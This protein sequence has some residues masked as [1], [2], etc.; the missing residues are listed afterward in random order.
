MLY[1]L[2]IMLLGALLI[3]Y[4]ALVVLHLLGVVKMTKQTIRVKK[5]LIPFYYFTNNSKPKKQ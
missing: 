1:R 2:I 5:L 4:Y 3:L